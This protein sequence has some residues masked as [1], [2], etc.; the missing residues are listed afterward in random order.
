MAEVQH[1]EFGW[2][3]SVRRVERSNIFTTGDMALTAKLQATYETK[4]QAKQQRCDPPLTG[5]DLLACVSAA[6]VSR[7]VVLASFLRLL[8]I[9]INSSDVEFL[10]LIGRW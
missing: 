9:F 6:L 10:N 4:P 7:S 1:I 5:S 3:M 8:Y 2:R